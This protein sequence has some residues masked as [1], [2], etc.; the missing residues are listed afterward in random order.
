MKTKIVGK[1]DLN[2]SETGLQ[3]RSES[4]PKG[5]LTKVDIVSR[6]LKQ[7]YLLYSDFY[8]HYSEDQKNSAHEQLNIVLDILQEYRY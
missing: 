5:Y 4:M 1:K 6:V 3:N 2:S 8:K 7:K